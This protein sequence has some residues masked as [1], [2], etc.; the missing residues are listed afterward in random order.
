MA[1]MVTRDGDTVDVPDDQVQ[2]L[3]QSGTHGLPAGQRVNMINPHTKE[4][5]TVDTTEAEKA[6]GKG[7]A[8]APDAYVSKLKEQHDYGEGAGNMLKAAAAGVARG[9]TFGL[10][11]AAVRELSPENADKLAKLAEYNPGS[12]FVGQVGGSIAP[13]VAA[14]LVGAGPEAAVGEVSAGARIAGSVAKQAAWGGAFG[15]GGQISEDALGNKELTAEHLLASAGKGALYGAATGAALEALAPVANKAVDAYR[16]ASAKVADH[17]DSL[18]DTLGANALENSRTASVDLAGKLQTL[19]D[20]REDFGKAYQGDDGI[21]AREVAS[22]T[23]SAPLDPVKQHALETLENMNGQLEAMRAAK[24]TPSTIDTVQQ[25]INLAADAVGSA[26][27][28][29]GVYGAVKKTQQELGSYMKTLKGV[30]D[31]DA[32][33]KRAIQDMYHQGLKAHLENPAVYGPELAARETAINSATRDSIVSENGDKRAG[34]DG[35]NKLFTKGD[36][37][38]PVKV[39]RQLKYWATGDLKGQASMQAVKDYLDSGSRMLQEGQTSLAGIVSKPEGLADAF[40]TVSERMKS[41][42]QALDPQM[43]AAQNV[44]GKFKNPAGNEG[45]RGMVAKGFDR[46]PL[47]GPMAAELVKNPGQS[48]ETIAN[49]IRMSDQVTQK[50]ANG[51]RAALQFGGGATPSAV[52]VPLM[53]FAQFDKT[54]QHLDNI[55][56]NP[57]A[58]TQQVNQKLGPRLAQDA[59]TVAQAASAKTAAQVQFLQSKIPRD[60]N[61]QYSMGQS[62]WKPSQDQLAKFARYKRA[63]DDPMSVIA[64]M[65]NGRLTPEAVEALRVT[66]PQIY[67]QVLST[68]MVQASHKKPTY[69]GTVQL[70]MLSGKAMTRSLATPMQF[71]RPQM[72]QQHVN[73]GQ[74]AKANFAGRIQPQFGKVRD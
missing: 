15:A 24:L 25:R 22:K 48:V 49:L 5:V 8:Y 17:L 69:H 57:A 37:V 20:A 12:S 1:T 36:K 72:P 13:M 18:A 4:L 6:F 35:F 51:T 60:P 66:A 27:D 74:L 3:F 40:N 21:R 31:V 53:S 65:R 2:N 39:E 61:A 55:A 16:E 59:P 54:S 73:T 68:A 41:L 63:V 42:Q 64:D 71:A 7:Y 45:I 28:V 30:T 9:A 46:V 70:S 50:I 43:Q 62:N 23:V 19:K 44:M 47:V 33:T 14:S 29:A 67:Q 52:G 11:D 58:L 32:Q 56:S 34:I 10:S 26:D 38:D